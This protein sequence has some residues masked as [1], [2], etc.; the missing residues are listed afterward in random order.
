[1]EL[2]F[3]KVMTKNPKKDGQP[4]E[5]YP[6]FL[7]GRSKDLMVQGQA[8]YAIW[9][10]ET[11]LWSR[12]EY[13]VQRIVD[14]AIHEKVRELQDGG[15]AATPKTMRSNS[16]NVW[17]QYKR[18]IKNASDNSHPLDGKLTFADS[19]SKKSDYSSRRLS[20]KLTEGSIAAYEE[21]V[22]RLYEP[23][24]RAKFE[25]ALG[26]IIQGDAKKIQKFLVFYGAPGTGK[27]TVM[28]IAYKL[29]GGLVKDG[30]Y[31]AMF[32]AKALVGNNN[33]FATEAFKDN[34]LL[35]I[36]HDGDLSRI[37]DNSKLNSIVS[38][39]DMR[40][41]EK[42]KATYDTKINAFLF[43]G[44]NKPVKITDAKS[45]LIRRLIDVNPTGEKHDPERYFELISQIDFELGAIAYHCLQVYRSMGKNYYN[46]YKPR[47]MML[48]T[49]V[50]FN[51]IEDHWD[52]FNY[53][54][55]MTLKQAWELYK[56]WVQDAEIDFSLPRYKFRD[57]LKDY[58]EEFHERLTVDGSVAR[59]VYVGFHSKQFK[60]PV[61]DPKTKEKA[62]SLVLEEQKSILDEM[63]S[64]LPA[65]Y[66]NSMGNPKLYWDDSERLDKD[67]TP[68]VP[69]PSQVV[70]TVLGDLDTTKLHFLKLP[71]NHIVIDFDLTD[72]SGKKSREANLKAASAW[73]PT[74]AEFS[75]SGNGVHLHYIYDGDTSELASEYSEGIEIK[76]FRGNGSLRRMLSWCNNLAV[77]TISSGLPFR[78]K[79]V[80]NTSTIQSEAGLRNMVIK[81]LKKGVHPG[82]KP[83]IDFIDHLLREA[84]RNGLTFDLTDLRPKVM[85]FANNSTNQA[86][87]C[88]KKV[89]QM[90]FKSEGTVEEKEALEGPKPAAVDDRIVFFD[91][92]IYPNLFVI[93]W[94][95]HGAPDSSVVKMLNPTPAEVEQLMQFRLVGFNN[96]SYDNHILYAALLGASVEELYN[97][98]QKIIVEKDDNAKFGA[99]WGI[100][101]ADVYDY[102]AVKQSLKKWQIQLGIRH[103]E[104]DIPW[105]K[106]VPK[107]KVQKVLEYCANDVNS[108][109]KVFDHTKAD[110]Q[111]R[112]LLANLSGLTV[113]SSTR[114]HVMRILFGGERTP[115]KD[116]VYTDL[117]EM[118]PGYE[119]DP[120]AKVDKSTY[121]GE[122][123]GEGGYVYA[124]PGMYENVALLDVASMHPT[125]LIELNLFGKYTP[126]YIRIRDA[127]LAI[128][129]ASERWKKGEDS[130]ADW[131]IGEANK[132]LP[133]I[134]VTKENAKA[135]S[136]A[137]KLVIN[138]TYG[139]TAAKFPNPARDPRNKDN[140]VA[141]RGALFMIDLKNALQEMGV[142][143]IHIKTDSVKIPNATTD[144]IE[145]VKEFGAKYGYEFEHEATYKKICLVNDAVY[146]AKTQDDEWTATGAEFK[147]PYVFKR[148]FTREP[149]KFQDLC[150]TKQVQKGAMWLRYPEGDIPVSTNP[151]EE[152]SPNG[153]THI[154]RSGLFVAINPEQ[155][156][157]KGATLVCHRD[158]LGKDFAVPGTKGYLWADA[159][160]VRTLQEGAIE[161]MVFEPLEEAVEGTGSIADVIDIAYY[162]Q[163]A[164]DAYQSLAKFGDADEFIE[165]EA[166]A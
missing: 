9:D 49:D 10:P 1:M 2:D 157:L 82:T 61:E 28:D 103:M 13:T 110:F 51:F 53:Q 154:G 137:L 30:G 112:Q 128:K 66:T 75:K 90:P 147:H 119:F 125:S 126:N 95:Y 31:V 122:V 8:F 145:F 46:G 113:N 139:Y 105:D 146:I 38:H 5:V 156:M 35:A 121:R 136:D 102:A 140:I 79:P 14:E 63:Y 54:S 18:Y 91:I 64:G 55:T 37:E 106:P 7:V 41:N 32:D 155:T 159:E 164:E 148:L 142:Q 124:E 89:A 6:D 62:Y 25:W 43:M 162:N 86:P 120:Y 52:I 3:F 22:S 48:E 57:K 134:E 152:V 141:K 97:L 45:G 19:P 15:V 98:S 117:S 114:Q 143:V 92:E 12:D 135:L 76:V 144:V 73:P 81:N 149:I 132:L 44:T 59:S 21:L 153:G 160:V 24:E 99:A 84:E 69:K 93:C 87:Y 150:E 4:V 11:E 39:E 118:F 80:I 130:E 158:D 42:Y 27:S 123:V 115:Q 26:A 88:L 20:Y 108:L 77:A 71:E 129:H 17:S 101:Y 107:E 47:N 58:F 16:S 74:Y 60:E 68:F 133:G 165:A 65:Q 83:S 116:F 138:S 50:F 131:Y 67:G 166:T 104:M 40:I 78:E 109:E 33:A 96:R 100:S 72:E 36:Q 161:R 85:A 127:R 34:P 163:L 56:N 94:K 29:L 70:S 151:K 23:E 111:A